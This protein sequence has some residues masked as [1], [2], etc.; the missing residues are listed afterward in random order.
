[1]VGW[2]ELL[3]RRCMFARMRAFPHPFEVLYR[4]LLIVISKS[5]QTAQH[6][7]L[8]RQVWSAGTFAAAGWQVTLW[9][10]PLLAHVEHNAQELRIDESVPRSG[11]GDRVPLIRCRFDGQNLAAT[12]RR[13]ANSGRALYHHIASDGSVILSTHLALMKATG[14]PWRENADMLPELFLYRQ[15]CAPRTLISG[16]DQLA[17]GDSI[18]LTAAQGSWV[19][20]R[21]PGYNPP[22]V[23]KANASGAQDSKLVASLEERLVTAI[24]GSGASAAGYGCLLSGGLDSSVITAVLRHIGVTSTCSA[25]YPFE[26]EAN[27]TEYQYASSA[28]H[29]LN[30]RHD[31]YVPTMSDYLHGTIDSIAI[32]EEP[33]M[34]LQSVLV[35]LICKDVLRPRGVTVVPCGEGADG[36]FGGRLQRLLTTFMGNPLPKFALELPGVALALKAISQRTNR[37]GMIADLAGRSW[38]PSA[39]FTD[40]NHILWSLAVFGD[41]PWIRGFLN[42][43]DA[44]MVGSRPTVMAPFAGRDLRDCVSILAL[45]S[46]SS[47]TQVLWSKLA[48]AQG[49]CMTYPY[50]DDSVAA[51]TYSVPWEAK[52]SGPKPLL[53]A[54][55]RSLGI[56]ETIV[57][58]PKASFDVR[59]HRWAARYGVFEPLVQLALPLIDE[60][61]IRALQ[62][63]YVLKAHT[64][65]T[66]INHSIWKR[67][68]IMGESVQSLHE[69]LDCSMHDLRVLETYRTGGRI[70]MAAPGTTP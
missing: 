51:L 30:T 14:I 6:A 67:L 53:R 24:G 23:D 15:A 42:C 17:A 25:A 3:H 52:L 1:M 58:R 32:A 27:D 5:S 69:Q 37:W 39:P 7:G 22:L 43:S 26:D 63:D 50:L 46:E 40:P 41:R 10:D 59:P 60:H 33:V 21:V 57:S 49:M 13:V 11:P 4:V 47:Q 68:F 8:T 62:S 61:A 12:I 18:E 28:A 66:V 54:V 16:I 56:N 35:H 55:A 29:A 65:W 2:R 20:R 48:E 9:S 38:R 31:I 45:L 19:L 70:K 34:H 64:L 36:M 44:A